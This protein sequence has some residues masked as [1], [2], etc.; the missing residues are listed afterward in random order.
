MVVFCEFFC[1]L[2]EDN[3][4][5][6]VILCCVGSIGGFIR[7]KVDDV[8]CDGDIGIGMMVGCMVVFFNK[9]IDFVI[10]EV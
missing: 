3:F 5:G 2:F 7:V 4:V 9:F 1:I 10:F 6:G 8:L